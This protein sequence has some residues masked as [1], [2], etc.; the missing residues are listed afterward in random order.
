MRSQGRLKSLGFV[1]FFSANLVLFLA[2]YYAIQH[3]VCPIEIGVVNFVYLI[4]V[5]FLR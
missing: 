4:Q 3:C 5:I 2:C 1:K